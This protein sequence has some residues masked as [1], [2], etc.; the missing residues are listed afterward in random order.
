MPFWNPVPARRS[1]PACNL[2]PKALGSVSFGCLE[3]V[4]TILDLTRNQLKR[5]LA[6]MAPMRPLVNDKRATKMVS[7]HAKND[8]ALADSGAAIG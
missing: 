2:G 3:E 8:R 4:C 6:V 7:R 1:F 5:T